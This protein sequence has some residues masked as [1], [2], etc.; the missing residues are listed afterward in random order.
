M[1]TKLLKIAAPIICHPLA[2]I[3]NLSMYTS[4]FPSE[5]KKAKVTRIYK[6]GDKCDVGSYR[7]ISVLPVL[8]ALE[9]AVHDQLYITILL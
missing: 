4:T 6:A 9:R 5:W 1:S 2:Y 3:C 8:S 7:P